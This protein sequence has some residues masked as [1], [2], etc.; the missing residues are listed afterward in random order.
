MTG[1][2]L[3]VEDIVPGGLDQEDVPK[4]GDIISFYSEKNSWIEASITGTRT[5]TQHYYNCQRTDN[6]K[7]FGLYLIPRHLTVTGHPES[8]TFVQ[9]K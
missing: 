1:E 3:P 5:G 7:N 8:W 9:R 2:N 4:T 6:K